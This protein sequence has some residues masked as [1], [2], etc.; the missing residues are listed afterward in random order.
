MKYRLPIIIS[1]V[2]ITPTFA[3]SEEISFILFQNQIEKV[4][5]EKRAISEPKLDKFQQ[6]MQDITCERDQIDE[7]TY[8]ISPI[9]FIQNKFPELAIEDIAN[10]IRPEL[11]GFDSA[12]NNSDNESFDYEWAQPILQGDHNIMADQYTLSREAIATYHTLRWN[13]ITISKADIAKLNTLQYDFYVSSMDTSMREGC[14]LQNYEVALQTMDNFLLSPWQEL[15][16][17]Q[18][19][20]DLDYCRWTWPQNLDFYAGACGAATQVFRTSLIHPEINVLERFNHTERWWTYYGEKITGDDAAIYQNN[21]KLIIRN[22]GNRGIYFK[23]RNQDAQSYLIAISPKTDKKIHITRQSIGI[24]QI[25]I[26]KQILLGDTLQSSVD[27]ASAY[28]KLNFKS[29]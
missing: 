5:D 10:Y 20:T 14:T 22:D 8:R 2:Y 16:F 7:D 19:I 18:H 11:Q 24:R 9:C 15:D 26:N 12:Y 13:Q 6:K 27:F 1:L 21:K 3:S 4:I 29:N 28:T 23:T 25:N 17:D